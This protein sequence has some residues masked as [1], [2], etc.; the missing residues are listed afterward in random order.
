MANR[1]PDSTFKH[2][3]GSEA[4]SSIESD[5]DELILDGFGLDMYFGL[6]HYNNSKYK[7]KQKYITLSSSHYSDI[8]IVTNSGLIGVEG[9][10]IHNGLVSL[11]IAIKAWENPDYHKAIT[12]ISKKGRT[13]KIESNKKLLYAKVDMI[14]KSENA[15]NL[16]KD[17]VTRYGDN[18]YGIELWRKFF[19]WELPDSR[20]INSKPLVNNTVESVC[21]KFSN[22]ELNENS[23]KLKKEFKN[24]L[25]R[26]YISEKFLI[27]EQ[28]IEGRRQHQRSH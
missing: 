6:M 19:G 27:I 4:K 8:A 23:G 1:K 24:E 2:G 9:D 3:D 12:G 25:M 17:I 5:V 22:Y 20:G 21:R 15:K 16:I 13:S 10:Q 18:I 11:G 7:K 14:N 28:S 26:P